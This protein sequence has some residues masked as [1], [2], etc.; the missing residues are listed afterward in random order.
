MIL[1]T[2]GKPGY[3][4]G[5]TISAQIRVSLKKPVK[6]RGIVA[7]LVC[8]ERRL[9]KRT[10]VMDAYDHRENQELGIPRSTHLETE[11][12][13]SSKAWFKQEKK[14]SEEGMYKEGT[15]NVEFELPRDAKPTSHA[16]G[17]DNLIHIWTLRV[18]LD[19]PMALDE[20]A[21]KE[22]FVSGL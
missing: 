18:K 20:N 3:A 17:H 22:V 10:R 9:E 2:L 19:V 16:F 21:E 14:V 13:E 8:V 7:T 15:F 12:H 11:M 1:I 6:A 5:E 4:P